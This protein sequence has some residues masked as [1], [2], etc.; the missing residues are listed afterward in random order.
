LFNPARFGRF[1]QI[2]WVTSD[3]DRSIAMFREIYRIPS[4]FAH[5]SV[6]EA[7]VGDEVGPMRLRVALSD[8]DGTQL[9]LIEPIGGGIDAIYRDVLPTDGSFATVFHHVCAR[10]DGTKD[11]WDRYRAQLHP[12]RK[13]VYQ[14]EVGDDI[15]FA[16][17]DERSLLGHYIEHLWYTSEM[18]NWFDD[19]VPRHRTA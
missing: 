10:I 6:F 3:L 16:Y 7:R 17:T 18:Q 11:D 8:I 1:H 9:E 14:G 5:E 2:A 19:V 13:V 12:E 4:F 15:G